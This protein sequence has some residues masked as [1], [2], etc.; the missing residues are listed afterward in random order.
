MGVYP[1]PR[2]HHGSGAKNEVVTLFTIEAFGDECRG[3]IAGMSPEDLVKANKFIATVSKIYRKHQFVYLPDFLNDFM[4]G[5]TTSEIIKKYHLRDH[6]NFN[7]LTSNILGFK[8]GR[9]RKSHSTNMITNLDNPDW[10]SQYELFMSYSKIFN[11]PMENML[12]YNILVAIFICTILDSEYISGLDIKK[13]ILDSYHKFDK[14]VY[15]LSDIQKRESF[16]KYMETNLDFKLVTIIN[17][18]AEKS[19]LTTMNGDVSILKKYTN[20]KEQI[21][22]ILYEA[23]DGISYNSLVTKIMNEFPLLKY[24][25]NIG[26]WELLID[27][28]ENEGLLTCKHAP[29]KHNLQYDQ[30][31]T[32]D[33]YETK[34]HRIKKQAYAGRIK[35]FGR[36]ITP[37]MFISELKTLDPGDLDDLDD[38]VTRIAGL[39]LSDALLPHS[40]KKDMEEFDFMVDITNYHFRPEQEKIMKKLN[41]RITSKMFHCKMMIDN[42]IDMA[43]MTRLRKMIPDGEQGVVFTCRP[44]NA[45]IIRMMLDDRTIQIIDESGIRD[46]CSITPTIPCRRQSVAEIMYGDDV[47]KLVQVK[48]LNYE[49]GLATVEMI[50]DGIETTCPIGCLK[51]A[52]PHISNPNDL[53]LA[54]R[55][56]VNFLHALRDVSGDSFEEGMITK[57]VNVYSTEYD[58]MKNI[59]PEHFDGLHPEIQYDRKSKHNKYVQFDNVYVTIG[60]KGS[61]KY[62]ECTCN[63]SFNEE[64]YHTLCKHLVAA[65]NH[66]CIS[67]LEWDE[68][69]HNIHRFTNKLIGLQVGNIE[70]M[71]GAIFDVLGSEPRETFKK[72]LQEHANI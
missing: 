68:A 17:H 30:L 10:K 63:H 21:H 65:I 46:W 7:A 14:S 41:F 36:N 20:I 6:N 12:N 24:V 39:I 55:K 31:F 9:S 19:H 47:G 70:R 72:Y 38:Q 44:V 11:I 58:L 4:N 50:F 22:E 45:K 37:N 15:P 33:N 53:E 16:G 26:I 34:I 71:I 60:A 49:S 66:L 2:D 43:T 1:P 56:Y 27:E 59:H 57:I 13:K 18:F 8:G 67:E 32:P 51:E 64:Y 29:W 5:L 40:P 3:M 62:F 35:F 61:G 54:T 69:S 52:M 23:K 25:P 48:S 28:L 42:E